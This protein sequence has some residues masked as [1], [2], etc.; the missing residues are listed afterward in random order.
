MRPTIAVAAALIS[1]AG[2]STTLRGSTVY[3]AAANPNP[4]LPENRLV[5]ANAQPS[6]RATLDRHRSRCI[7]RESSGLPDR[8]ATRHL[9]LDLQHGVE[10]VDQR[11][12]SSGQLGD[13]QDGFALSSAECWLHAQELNLGQKGRERIVDLVLNA[14]DNLSQHTPRDHVSWLPC[15][16]S[17]L[18]FI[19]DIRR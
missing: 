19:G 17:F 4:R 5:L 9:L 1:E 11:D 14:R 13:T 18:C 15:V 7:A 6:G 10:V 16:Q 3:V 8:L 12:D 2:W